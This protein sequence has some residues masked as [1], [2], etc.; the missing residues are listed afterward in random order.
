MMNKL[1]PLFIIAFFTSGLLFSQVD[2]EACLEPKKKTLKLIDKAK[3]KVPSEASK[4][5]REAIAMEPE[6]ATPYYEFAMYAYDQGLKA[7]EK[8][9]DPKRGDNYIS[10]AEKLFIKTIDRCSNFHSNCYYYL[11][12]INYTLDNDEKAMEY[13]KQFQEFDSEEM[14]RF[15]ND[16]TKR[17]K[18]VQEVL[19]QHK[20]EQSFLSEEVP[21]SPKKVENV[22]T[23]QDEYF[24]MI[25]P[26]NELIF[27]TRKVDRTAKGDIISTIREEFTWSK[28]KGV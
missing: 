17:L 25:S 20:E 10:V 5:F 23:H 27:Y 28:R 6:N 3:S 13:F 12:I 14:D 8:D 11:G 4:I 24:P 7:Y 16:H 18:D 1:Y 19:D 2:D 22:S 9:P 15:S 21:F 26:D